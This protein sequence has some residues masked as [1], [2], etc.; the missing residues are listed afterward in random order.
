LYKRAKGI[1]G[2]PNARKSD[3]V[4][5]FVTT[6]RKE[7]VM[8]QSSSTNQEDRPARVRIEDIPA[9]GEVLDEEHLRL[10]SGGRSG[11]DGTWTWDRSGNPDALV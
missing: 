10:V 5:Q 11:R 8:S 6:Q 1:K 3:S 2:I 4:Q 9:V 7:I